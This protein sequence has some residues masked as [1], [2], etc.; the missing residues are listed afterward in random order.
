LSNALHTHDRTWGESL[1]PPEIR[2]IFDALELAEGRRVC[3]LFGGPAKAFIRWFEPTVERLGPG[4]AYNKRGCSLTAGKFDALLL[5]SAK[6]T[7]AWEILSACTNK[8]F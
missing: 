3:V 6:A 5:K 1:T 8:P 7:W 4:P 2:H